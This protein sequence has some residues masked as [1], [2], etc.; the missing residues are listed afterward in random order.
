MPSPNW[1]YDNPNFINTMEPATFV[2]RAYGV[3]DNQQCPFPLPK[4]ITRAD[5]PNIIGTSKDFF[6][7]YVCSWKVDGQRKHLVFLNNKTCVI[8]RKDQVQFM[9]D[10]KEP[11]MDG[12][13]FDCELIG[14]Q[15]LIFDMVIIRHKKDIQSKPYHQ[16]LQVAKALVE[17]LGCTGKD[18]LSVKPI[19]NRDEFSMKK[20]Q[21]PWPT[22]GVIFTPVHQPVVESDLPIFKW[23]P[24]K[25][26]TVDFLV[27]GHGLYCGDGTGW[28]DF[29]ATIPDLIPSQTVWEFELHDD[30]WKP[31][32][33]RPDKNR[34]NSRYVVESTLKSRKEDIKLEELLFA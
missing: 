11:H 9:D 25:D 24:T 17:Q 15:I 29:W 23:K 14:N 21:S 6:K 4:N 31:I 2:R 12:T 1:I 34:G 16:R 33:I 30:Q 7:H 27:K 22:D 19:F 5:I 10:L 26:Q 3:Q 20:D 32:R 18:R 28:N 8:D 13:M